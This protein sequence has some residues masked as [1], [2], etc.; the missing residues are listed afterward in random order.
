MVVSLSPYCNPRPSRHAHNHT[1]RMAAGK[2]AGR[3][4]NVSVKVRVN[5]RVR[6][7]AKDKTISNRNQTCLR[8]S[9]AN[10]AAMTS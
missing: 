10:P 3:S 4:D 7:R 2:L 9:S 5:V 8:G 1:M 6:A